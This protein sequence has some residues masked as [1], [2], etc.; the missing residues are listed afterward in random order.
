MSEQIVGDRY[1]MMADE[2]NWWWNNTVLQYKYYR[3]NRSA[4]LK[5]SE[6]LHAAVNI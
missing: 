3:F 6:M 5:H 2:L 1:Y 4:L